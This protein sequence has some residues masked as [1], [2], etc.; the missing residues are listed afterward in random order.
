MESDVFK[1]FLKGTGVTSELSIVDRIAFNLGEDRDVVNRIIEEFCLSLRRGLDEYKG[2][3]GDY[4]GEQLHWEISGRALFNLLGFMDQF[5]EKYE[6]EPGSAAEHIYR[7]F[8][9]NEWNSF[10][11]EYADALESKRP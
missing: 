10:S 2:F 1:C 5:S 4:I 11:R 7:L 3:N 8:S 9:A 6:W